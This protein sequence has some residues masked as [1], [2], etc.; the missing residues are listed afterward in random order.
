MLELLCVQR[1]GSIK[2]IHLSY[3]R[4]LKFVLRL[5]RLWSGL[6]LVLVLVLR[7]CAYSCG[8]VCVPV[9]RSKVKVTGLQ[10]AKN[11]D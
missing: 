9:K 7:F 2:N 3:L 8:G 5:Y 4:N 1:E 6:V 11:L 10:S